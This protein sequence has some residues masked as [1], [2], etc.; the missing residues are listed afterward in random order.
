VLCN[1]CLSLLDELAQTSDE[2][3]S[4]TLELGRTAAA[5]PFHPQFAKC[6]LSVKQLIQECAVLQSQLSQHKQ[7][8]C[9]PSQRAIDGLRA[10][11]KAASAELNALRA[12]RVALSDGMDVP[13]KRE[14]SREFLQVM[15]KHGVAATRADLGYIQLWDPAEGVLKI[16][17]QCGFECPFL[18]HF[19]LVRPEDCTACSEALRTGQPVIV[20]DVTQSAIFRGNQSLEVLLD[21]GVRAI[22][23]TPVCTS[24]GTLVGVLSTH[25]RRPRRPTDYE[26][27]L[28]GHLAREMGEHIAA[29]DLKT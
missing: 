12:Y 1:I 3:Q 4:M 2:L 21:A 22:Q 8:D 19:Q 14:T 17:A 26:L 7:L 28:I 13:S 27:T 6:L 29:A 25:C 10:L 9:D 20:E 18:E 16:E 5:G 23:S 24:S 11:H 15:L